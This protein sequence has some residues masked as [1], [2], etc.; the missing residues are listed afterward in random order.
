[1][2]DSL[3]EKY[4]VFKEPDNVKSHPTPI[5]ATYEDHHR[6]IKDVEE[7]EEFVF[8]LKPN[9]DEHALLAL[10]VYAELVERDFPHLAE[11]LRLALSVY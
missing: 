4:R 9:T 5:L 2:K 10:K 8:V 11:D 3:Y 7:I 6:K 1:M